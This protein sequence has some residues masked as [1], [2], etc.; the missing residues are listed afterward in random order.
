MRGRKLS[1]TSVKLVVMATMALFAE[2]VYAASIN[3]ECN[4]YRRSYKLLLNVKDNT[5]IARVIGDD[6]V[7]YSI[8]RIIETKDGYVVLGNA[9]NGGPAYELTVGK[10]SEITFLLSETNKQT[11][12][13]V[14]R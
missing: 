13:C 5:L 2:S 7:L 8:K 14:R 11:D 4:N 6:D 9:N 12:I 3:L 1:K 10:K